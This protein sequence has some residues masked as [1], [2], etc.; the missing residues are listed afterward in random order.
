MMKKQQLHTLCVSPRCSGAGRKAFTLIELLVVIA[1][2]AILASLLL[3]ALSRARD[4]AQ[5]VVC[6]SNYKQLYLGLAIYADDFD[7]FLPSGAGVKGSSGETMRVRGD[8]ANKTLMSISPLFAAGSLG[9]DSLR[10]TL[11]PTWQNSGISMGNWIKNMRTEVL[12]LGRGFSQ[13][14]D[15]YRG[16]TVAYGVQNAT[17]MADSVFTQKPVIMMDVMGPWTAPLA[18]NEVGQTHGFQ[19][20][21]LTYIDGSI[22]SYSMSTIFSVITPASSTKNYRFSFDIWS[23]VNDL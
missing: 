4:R 12:D 1:I 8:D 3:P 20:N 23:Q 19:S 22:R 15:A 13:I 9:D 21:N 10:L 7:G 18:T 17:R 14:T 11:C 2:I 6:Q 5:L 16:Y